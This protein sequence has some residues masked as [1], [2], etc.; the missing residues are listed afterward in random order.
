M[1]VGDLVK[2][3]PMW[4]GYAGNWGVITQVAQGSTYR[5]DLWKAH[6]RLRCGRMIYVD[7]EYIEVISESR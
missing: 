2:I 6:I 5:F 4:N 1:K 3:S 7:E